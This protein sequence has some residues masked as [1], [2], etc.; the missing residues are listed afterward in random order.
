PT[1]DPRQRELLLRQRFEQLG[2]VALQFLAGLLAKQAYGKLQ[3]Q[4]LLALIAHYQRDDVQAA[5]ERAV[6]FGA[7]SLTAMQR[8]LAAQA[9]PKPLLD[10]LAEQERATLDPRLSQD[11]V[12]P[13]PSSAYQHLLE[14][15]NPCHE[16]SPEPPPPAAEPEPP[17]EQGAL[18]PGDSAT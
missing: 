2:P 15:E 8:I 10:E 9:R 1:D 13:R 17:S 11:P 16:P 12:G 5:L 18:D 3:A 7:F 14:P 4:Q 6:R